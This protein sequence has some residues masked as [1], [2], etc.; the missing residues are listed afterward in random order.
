MYA[1]G[2]SDERVVPTKCSNKEVRNT[3]G[4][5]GGEHG[6]KPI[7]QEEVAT[8]I[9][10]T[11]PRAGLSV[12]P[13]IAAVRGSRNAPLVLKAGA[14]CA[15]VRSYGSVRGAGS[16]SRPYRNTQGVWDKFYSVKLIWKR[17]RCVKTL[18]ARLAFLLISKLYRRMYADTGIATDSARVTRSTRW[19][20][21]IAKPCRRLFAGKPMPDLQVPG[22]RADS[23]VMRQLQVLQ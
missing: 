18:K 4:S 13:R 20:R 3:T 17:A 11:G 12:S 21:W 16:N 19:A 2:E 14:V 1:V 10:R 5:F 8:R 6:G 9:A 22:R 23:H 7:G 15:K